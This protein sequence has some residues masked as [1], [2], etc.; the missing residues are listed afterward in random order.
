MPNITIPT[1]ENKIIQ[2]NRGEALGTIFATKNVDF[3]AN[4]SNIRLSERMVI[5]F[6]S[7]D[8]G[9]LEVPVAFVRSNADTTDRWWT[10][11]QADAISTSDGL[12]FKTTNTD[13][14][15]TWAQDAIAS[16][17]TTAMDDMVKFG[18]ANSYDRLVVATST[19]LA[20]MNN[21]TWT[22]SWWQ[23]T[24]GQSTLQATEPHPLHVFKKGYGGF[25]KNILIVGDGNYIHTVT[26][27][28][29]VDEEDLMARYRHLT[30]P[31]NQR[32]IWI[33][34]SSTYVYI[35]TQDVRGMEA[36]VFVWDG[37][38]D[39]Y[40]VAISV[41][42]QITYAGVVMGNTPYCVNGKGQLL[43]TD[44]FSEVAVFPVFYEKRR[45]DD[46]LARAQMVHRNGM[47]IIDDKIHILISGAIEGVDT[48]LLENMP[49]GI[50]EYDP[51]SGLYCKYT[52]G[53][54][55][56][57]DND[58]GAAAIARNGA[59]KEVQ[60][61]TGHFLAGASVY[62]DDAG[63]ELK[64]IFVS[65][66][67]ATALQR[68]YFITSQIR[69]Q[70]IRAFWRRMWVKF[71][72]LENS[73]DRIIVKYRTSKD[74]NFPTKATITWN[75]TSTFTSIDSDFANVVAG[76]EIEILCGKGAGTTAHVSTITFATPTYTITLD[77]AIPGATGT[78]QV[79]IQNYIKLG[80]ISDQTLVRKFYR[81][82][83]R[84]AWIQFK[85]ELRGT[86]TSPEL[87]N[88]VIEFENSQR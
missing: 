59:L 37:I 16:S 78:A 39:A 84:E 49:S 83:K 30:L 27:E 61:D 5:E 2:T 63:T 46:D 4:R 28:F 52:F 55:K 77:E 35:G 87:E 41:K 38:S 40:Q 50:W 17:P 10:L 70:D 45:W 65:Q 6:D 80:T 12:L 11:V 76:N 34:S 62:T 82:A 36:F 51:N 48:E 58:W 8:D 26:E 32:A 29:D 24:L 14:T 53:Q 81:I 13:P 47:E 31:P 60:Q 57:T 3:N 56:S 64:A 22:A 21:G 86:E 54:Y 74:K 20:M 43:G 18:K 25:S 7:F 73:T 85:V 66:V 9:D 19:N 72:K 75:S 88:I 42:D 69:A 44:A 1:G 23:T 15:G 68:G 33:R 71:K 79:R 67:D